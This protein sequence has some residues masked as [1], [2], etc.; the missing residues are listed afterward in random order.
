VSRSSEASTKPAA[1]SLLPGRSA[2][3]LA[4]CALA[5]AA[6][7][8]AGA[9]PLPLELSASSVR[10]SNVAEGG[11]VALFAGQRWRSGFASRLEVWTS[12]ATDEDA[13]GVVEFP[14]EEA[15]SNASIWVAIDA[16]SGRFGSASPAEGA[17]FVLEPGLGRGAE[18]GG[19]PLVPGLDGPG[20]AHL[21]LV[22]RGEGIWI[23]Q[24]VD[25]GL[26]ENTGLA[27]GRTLWIQPEWEALTGSDPSPGDYRP[28][29]LLIAIDAAAL[30]FDAGIFGGLNELP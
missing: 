30:S 6:A 4:V 3:A 21:F 17:P 12:V 27:D 25:G 14:L 16:S 23:A 2:L 24:A 28:S 26:A 18:G 7:T 1:F 19:G 9:Q 8:S 20:A 10:V 22:R 5:L 29:D 13:D 11:A 15:P